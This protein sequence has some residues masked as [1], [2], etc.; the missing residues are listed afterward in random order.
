MSTPEQVALPP[1]WTVPFRD[2]DSQPGRI[3]IDRHGQ[4]AM[5]TM[6]NDHVMLLTR[7]NAVILAAYLL[8]QYRTEPAHTLIEPAPPINTH[9]DDHPPIPGT[10]RAA[11]STDRQHFV[12]DGS[13]QRMHVSHRIATGLC[14]F[15][16]YLDHARPGYEAF[17]RCTICRIVLAAID[18]TAPRTIPNHDQPAVYR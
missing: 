11:I 14:R 1:M 5:L 6:P 4:D 10:W 17:R 13:P 16:G 3:T 12:P 18:P 7:D 8:A 15:P 2:R 9:T